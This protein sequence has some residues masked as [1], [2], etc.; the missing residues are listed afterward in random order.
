M[1][2]DIL[3][4]D[5]LNSFGLPAGQ[6]QHSEQIYVL[7]SSQ[8]REII[9]RAIKQAVTSLEARVLDLEDEVRGV[10]PR[11][12]GEAPQDGQESQISL[13]QVVQDLQAR[14]EGL[15]A[16]LEALQELR[17]WIEA[18]S[19]KVNRLEAPKISQK[20]EARAEKIAKYLKERPD[21]R[22][23]FTT[24][25]GH[26]EAD[27]RRLNEAIKLLMARDPGRYGILCLPGDKRGKVLILLPK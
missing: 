5:S 17:P 27:K 20:T 11:E 16:E 25:K 15:K 4:V 8:L 10:G 24:L 21:H 13:L 2:T 3:A 6:E 19:K 9:A 7:S 22:A 1:S 12:G 14:N 26:L 18:L 23:T